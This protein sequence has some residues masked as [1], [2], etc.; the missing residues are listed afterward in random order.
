VV[1]PGVVVSVPVPGETGVVPTPVAEERVPR[2]NVEIENAK[3]MMINPTTALR[4]VEI[5]SLTL[6]ASPP[7]V[8]QRNPAYR[9]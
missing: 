5:A 2:T 1:G 4:I 6:S 7:A 9:R 8:I 3:T